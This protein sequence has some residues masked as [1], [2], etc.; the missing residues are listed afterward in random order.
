MK[1]EPVGAAGVYARICNP[2]LLLGHSSLQQVHLRA[3]MRRASLQGDTTLGPPRAQVPGEEKW[4]PART[5]HCGT[6]CEGRS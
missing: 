3:H 4:G 6:F 2:E 5:R 1:W